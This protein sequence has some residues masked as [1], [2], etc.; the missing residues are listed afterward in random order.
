MKLDSLNNSW[1]LYK[2]GVIHPETVL[3]LLLLAVI[4]F[5]VFYVLRKY[6]VPYL[7]SRQAVKKYQNLLYRLEVVIWISYAILAL[8]QLFS[9]SFYITSAMVIIAILAGRNFWR[10]L[11]A[12]IAFRLENKF[13][14]G[15]PVKFDEYVG[16][17]AGMNHRNLLIK[18]EKEELVAIPFRKVSSSAFIKRQAKGKLHSSQI[19]LQL[20]AKSYD[21][22]HPVLM[23]WLFECPWNVDSDRS[24]VKSLGPGMVQLTVYAVD[25]ASIQKTQE[26]LQQRLRK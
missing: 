26:Y 8:Y 24:N 13:E 21:E 12:G 4:L 15:D 20:G 14:V 23:K 17:L 9:D 10:D 22:I 1:S 5:G 16:S 11:F 2:I 3:G 19:T 18:T 6:V 25:K 7:S